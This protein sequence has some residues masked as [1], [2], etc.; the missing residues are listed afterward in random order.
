MPNQKPSSSMRVLSLSDQELEFIYSPSVAERFADVDFVLG[1]GDLA[2]YYLEYL[3]DI[4]GKPVFHVRGNHAASVEYS[5]TGEERKAPWGGVD[6]HRR[7]VNFRGLLMAGFEGSIRYRKGP[8]MYTQAEMWNMVLAMVPRLIWNRARYGRALDVL[9]THAP[10]WG[11][12]DAPDPAHRGF[13]AFG[14]LLRV[15]RPLYHFHGHIHVYN[16]DAPVLT[17]YRRT[18]VINT[19]GYRETDLLIPQLRDGKP[20]P[21]GGGT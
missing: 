14:W 7:V 19:Y 11:V 2:Y 15:F 8:F 18:Q 16:K 17:R 10:P 21:G 4:L 13:K 9:A 5:T 6:L 3:V 20:M 1:C 12:Q